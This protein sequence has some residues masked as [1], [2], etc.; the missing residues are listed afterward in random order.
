[1]ADA[2]WL[3]RACRVALLLAAACGAPRVGDPM[4]TLADPGA[5]PTSHEAAMQAMDAKGEASKAYVQ[6]LKRIVF[7]PG[8]VQSVREAAFANG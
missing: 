5:L 1:M 4:K 3:R 2:A 7:Q 6:Q 8:Y